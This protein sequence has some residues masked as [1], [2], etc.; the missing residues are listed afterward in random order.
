MRWM[1]LAAAMATSACAGGVG[2]TVNDEGVPRFSSS[3]V[4]STSLVNFN[5]FGI[6]V[7]RD[8]VHVQ[9]VTYLGGCEVLAEDLH[10]QN[11]ESDLEERA[12]EREQLYRERTPQDW[13]SLTLDITA[14]DETDI[15]GEEIDVGGNNDQSLSAVL[16]HNK[17]FP[18]ANGANLEFDDDCFAAEDGELEIA[19]AKKQ[20]ISVG[21]ALE[22]NDEDG[23][24]AGDVDVSGSASFCE[25]ADDEFDDLF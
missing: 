12:Q 19:F 1:V 16:C 11:T 3:S 14:E 8:I 22:L 4:V 5:L 2:G 7:D 9:F 25:I 10:I 20:G 23:D 17:D 24:A 13:W 21:G 18:E 15:D 6:N